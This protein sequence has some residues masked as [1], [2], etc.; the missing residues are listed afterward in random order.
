MS[1]KPK[2][3]VFNPPFE[4]QPVAASLPT[5]KPTA[6]PVT[7]KR[8]TG[9]QTAEGKA[10]SSQNAVKHGLLAKAVVFKSAGVQENAEEFDK[11]LAD[12]TADLQ[13]SGHMEEAIVE[14]IATCQWRLARAYRYEASAL[15]HATDHAGLAADV[16]TIRAKLLHEQAELQHIEKLLANSEEPPEALPAEQAKELADWEK[17]LRATPAGIL[18]DYGIPACREWAAPARE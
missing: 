17:E 6:A 10:R 8:A 13:P 14:R 3:V 4:K 2:N 16:E 12:L 9:P 15:E 18:W 1:S 11:L 5:A 7:T